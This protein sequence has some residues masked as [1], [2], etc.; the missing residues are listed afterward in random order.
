MVE[1]N[2][3]D[4]YIKLKNANEK[5]MKDLEEI[6]SHNTIVLKPLIMMKS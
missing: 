5:L 4:E 6:K 3:Y 2:D 1:C